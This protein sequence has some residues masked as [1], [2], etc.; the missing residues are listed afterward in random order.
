MPFRA[1]FFV[2]N[3]VFVWKL[4]LIKVLLV[5][6]LHPSGS[7]KLEP[8]CQQPPIVQLRHKLL[9]R[10]CSLVFGIRFQRFSCSLAAKP[11]TSAFQLGGILDLDF[12]NKILS[13]SQ[14]PLSEE[15]SCASWQGNIGRLQV[16][17]AQ[18]LLCSIKFPQSKFLKLS[19]C[20]YP[21]RSVCPWLFGGQYLTKFCCRSGA[22][23]P[24]RG[25]A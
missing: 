23:W 3:F 2:V 24:T 14:L 18:L 7:F 15:T 11:K 10:H 13:S 12:W 22:V 6:I 4:K 1:W 17:A 8:C 5:L 21:S 25:S 9:A 16:C 19:E 20:Q